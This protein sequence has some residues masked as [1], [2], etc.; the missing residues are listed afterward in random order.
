MTY[1]T[2]E[3][4]VDELGVATLMLNQPEKHN[5]MSATM[6]T[7]L[8]A[9]AERIAADASI[10]VVVLTGSGKSFCAGGDL[11]WMRSQFQA[12]R[13]TRV[14]EA[15]KLAR[16]L[17]D[18]NELPKPL[19]GRI[20]GQAYGG[21]IGLISICD[22]A[23]GHHEATFALTETRLGLIPATISPYVIARMGEGNARQVFMSGQRF[24]S[25]EA[26]HLGLLADSAL[27]EEFD[28]KVDARVK[29]YLKTAPGA[30]AKAKALARSL[31][32][33]IDEQTMLATANRL[34]DCWEDAEAQE[35]IQAFFDREKPSWQT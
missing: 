28:A 14:S 17:R 8:S 26:V 33:R 23:V 1:Q 22:A 10:R 19:V 9:A 16:M 29:A 27:D 31:G 24:Q 32:P 30:V 35:G 13:E 5:A 34:A 2:L 4:S 11:A 3:L 12:D 25:P 6:I 18:L 7:E 20:N 15:M 21:G